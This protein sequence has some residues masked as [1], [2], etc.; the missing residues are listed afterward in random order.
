LLAAAGSARTDSA[1]TGSARF[2]SLVRSMRGLLT[3]YLRV[4]GAWRM[5]AKHEIVRR[6][7]AVITL[8][9]DLSDQFCL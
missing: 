4:N 7:P 5:A 8:G 6:L 9:S 1:R 2:A 3:S